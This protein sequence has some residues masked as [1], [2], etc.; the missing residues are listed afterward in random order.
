MQFDIPEPMKKTTIKLFVTILFFLQMKANLAQ[1]KATAIDLNKYSG[2][3][4]IIACIPS[5]VDKKW[6]YVAETYTIN[7]KGN[8]DI[9]TTYIK[10]GSTKEK[11]LR[12]IGF[13]HKETSNTFWD[14]QFI[15][16]FT[17]DYLI[18][19]CAPD[20][21]YS[22]VGHPKKKYFYILARESKIPETLYS[23]L[24]ERYKAQGYDMAKLRKLKQ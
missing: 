23:N 8:I 22:I 15:W 17:A 14:V 12:S 5:P 2:K 21:T 24:V 13:P 4:F 19:E 3:W 9:Y 6:D 16:P 20:Y 10:E 7:K 1:T 18:E 11:S